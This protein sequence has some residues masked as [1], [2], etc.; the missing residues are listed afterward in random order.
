VDNGYRITIWDTIVDGKTENAY[1]EI[2]SPKGAL[3]LADVVPIVKGESEYWTSPVTKQKYAT[4]Y[5]IDIPSVDT[6]LT[7]KVYE[8]MPNQEIVSPQGDDKY[9]A[10]CTFTGKFMGKKV[11]GFNYVELVGNFL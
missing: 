5:I 8:G 11:S 3:T 1:A 10:A 4:R 6:K 7:A 9:E 2:L